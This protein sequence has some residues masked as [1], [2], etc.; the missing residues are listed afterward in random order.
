MNN[1]AVFYVCETYLCNRYRQFTWLIG[2]GFKPVTS[3]KGAD[4]NSTWVFNAT[5]DLIDC[6]NA[7]VEDTRSRGYGADITY[8]LSKRA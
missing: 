7:Y 1:E 8:A 5:Q 3:Y 2:H 4:N 6:L